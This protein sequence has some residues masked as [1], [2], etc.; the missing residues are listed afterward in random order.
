MSLPSFPNITPKINICREDAINLIISSI[1]LEEIS[2]SQILDAESEKIKHVLCMDKHKCADLCDIKEVNESAERMIDSITRLETL[3]QMKLSNVL[4]LKKK[5]TP[6]C[7]N[8]DTDCHCCE[9][10]DT[11]CHCCE[12]TQ[13]DRH[14]CEHTEEDRHCRKDSKSEHFSR[15]TFA[16]WVPS[17][18]YSKIEPKTR[19]LERK[20]M[21]N[22]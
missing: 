21:F 20:Y 9:N 3:L 1:A 15:K 2:L 12:H 7:E 19:M 22:R 18:N 10:T 6:C 13:R 11:D 8:T 16:S 4:Q 17:C 5:C 14:C